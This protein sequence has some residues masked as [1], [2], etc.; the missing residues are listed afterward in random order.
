MKVVYK[1]IEK[2][3]YRTLWEHLRQK[4]QSKK[5]RPKKTRA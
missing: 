5:P 3:D 2:P 1:N 4:W